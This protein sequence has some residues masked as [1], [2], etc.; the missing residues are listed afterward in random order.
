MPPPKVIEKLA[1]EKFRGHLG[2]LLREEPQV[3]EGRQEMP[4]REAR[5]QPLDCLMGI[6]E[7]PITLRIIAGER[8]KSVYGVEVPSTKSPPVHLPVIPNK[9]IG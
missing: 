8:H 7:N 6:V 9:P 2:E 5:H 1:V 3:E 4:R